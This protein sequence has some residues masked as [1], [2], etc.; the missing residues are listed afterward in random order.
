MAGKG[1]E[2][3]QAAD[4]DVDEDEEEWGDPPGV[5]KGGDGDS[6]T[7]FNTVDDMFSRAMAC[8]CI[9]AIRPIYIHT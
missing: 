7:G 1:R 4:E 2:E 8:I 5:F 6:H 3:E 9:F